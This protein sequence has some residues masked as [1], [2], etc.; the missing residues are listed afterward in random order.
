MSG[1]RILNEITREATKP[2]KNELGVMVK[3]E[4]RSAKLKVMTASRWW[5]CNTDFVLDTANNCVILK[6]SDPSTQKTSII[7]VYVSLDAIEA[8]SVVWK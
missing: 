3:G 1:L 5:F 6:V 8:I 2:R 7:D 4:R